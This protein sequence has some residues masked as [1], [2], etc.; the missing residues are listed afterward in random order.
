MLSPWIEKIKYYEQ[1]A[2]HLEKA[3]ADYTAMDQFLYQI[4]YAYAATD[5]PGQAR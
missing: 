5:V 1:L 2:S 4:V 3:P